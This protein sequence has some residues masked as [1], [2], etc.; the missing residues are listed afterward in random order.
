MP[1]EVS[2]LDGAPL[3][4]PAYVPA[5]PSIGSPV[6]ANAWNVYLDSR[7]DGRRVRRAIGDHPRDA[8]IAVVNQRSVLELREPGMVVD[9]APEF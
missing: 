4:V 2:A 6:V 3:P 1:L 5:C 8:K 7:E 9:D